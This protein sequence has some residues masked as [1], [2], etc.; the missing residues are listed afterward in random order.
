MGAAIAIVAA[1]A[2]FTAAV[3]ALWLYDPRGPLTAEIKLD[4]SGREQLLLTCAKCPDTSSV[5]LGEASAKFVEQRAELPLNSPLVIGDNPIVLE[6]E[7]T[8]GKRESVE[9]V[10]PVEY[11]V[12]ADTSPL[13]EA[14]PRVRVVVQAVPGTT[15]V[16]DGQPV[17]LGPDGT[18]SAEFDV[19]AALLG[20]AE[21]VE[22]LERSIPYAITPPGRATETGR[23]SIELGIPAL[24]IDAPGD[25]VIIDTETFVLAGRTLRGAKVSV[26]GRPIAVDE[27]GK[28][29]Q[30][31]NV[32][33]HGETTITVRASAPNQAPRLVPVKVKRVADLKPELEKI[34]ATAVSSYAEIASDPES[35]HGVTVAL[36][37]TVIEARAEHFASVLLLDVKS[38]CPKA[39]CFAKVTYGARV[40]FANG[41]RVTAVGK[42][43]GS[44]EGPRANTLVPAV[45]AEFVIRANQ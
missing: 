2:L 33:A 31:M 14:K 10:V 4:A 12:R 15:A 42:V 21:T 41:E 13:D 39:P 40:P 37:G 3:M 25:S 44:V 30:M 43:S 36:D 18:G 20:E 34:R 35:K 19:S 29:A 22:R 23:V 5:R 45:A 11:R 38:G 7:R 28:F 24:T 16:V 17:A 1:A 9:L 26:E 32:S 27:L 6:L 8:P